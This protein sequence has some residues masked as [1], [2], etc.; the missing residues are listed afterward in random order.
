MK[1]SLCKLGSSRPVCYGSDLDGGLGLEESPIEI[2]SAADLIKVG[3][4]VSVG[5][6]RRVGS[7]LVEIPTSFTSENIWVTCR[8]RGL[9]AL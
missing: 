3:D 7:Q 9:W 8:A 1:K 6:R 4:D 5:A 2:E